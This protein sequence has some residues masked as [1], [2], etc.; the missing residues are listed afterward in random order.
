[1]LQFTDTHSHIYDEQFSGDE[2]EMMQRATDAG[3]NKIYMPNCDSSTM[4]AMLQMTKKYPQQCFPMMGLHPCYV[5][6]NYTHELQIVADK[7]KEGTY[8][9]VGEIGLDYYWDI[10]FKEQQLE[11]FAYQI[12]LALQY[13]L[14]IIIHS[15]E[16]TPDCIEMVRKK[17]NGALKGIFHC[18]SGTIQEAKSIAG[19]GLYLG[20]GGVVT[21]KKS[22]LPDVIKAVGLQQIVLETDA[23]YL[24]P[25][26]YRG[27]RNESAYIPLIAAKLAEI[28][29]LPI[30]EIAEVSSRNAENIFAK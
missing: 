24:S 6:E 21:Y 1:M 29:E 11:A 25:V 14:P 9:G 2:T 13:N 30:E 19:L 20:I 22:N 28:L 3:V 15:R 27:K 26:P 16:S 7:L 18:Y 5:K 23:P 17:Q 10:T 8:Y 4:D 12:D